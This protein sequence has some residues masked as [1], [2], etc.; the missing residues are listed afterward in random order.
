MFITFEGIEGC[1]KTTQIDLLFNYLRGKGYKIIK[2]REPGG[3]A[4][5]ETLRET[6]LKTDSKVSP[7]C[8][9][10]IFAAMRAQHVEELIEPALRDG[11]IVLC[12]RFSD[13]TYAYQGYGRGLDLSTIRTLNDL[14]AHGI[15]PD[16]T[17]ILDCPA[18]E[19]LTRKARSA[20]M[21]RFERE[22]ISFHNRIRKGYKELAKQNR[23]RFLVLDGTDNVKT[24]QSAIRKKIGVI[25]RQ[26]G[27]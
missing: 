27:I 1:G 14:S 17:I 5:G 12:D 21:D 3:T 4:F 7:M 25:L 23:D 15:S 18:R 16:L 26:H 8:E 20:E 22:E 24:I 6:F 13:A 10:L 2:T 19:G 11:Y 9:L